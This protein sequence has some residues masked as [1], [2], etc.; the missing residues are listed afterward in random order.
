MLKRVEVTW[1]DATSLNFGWQDAE[2]Y[3]EE[4]HPVTITSVGY[5]IARTKLSLILA[6]NYSE[7]DHKLTQAISIP[8]GCILKIRKL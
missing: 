5:L 1:R 4:S 3:I 6:L 7:S 2:D 8:T